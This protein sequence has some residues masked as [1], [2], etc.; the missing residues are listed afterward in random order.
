MYFSEIR[1]KKLCI[2]VM[3]CVRTLF[4][5]YVYA[6]VCCV[7]RTVVNWSVLLELI[8]LVRTRAVL[9]SRIVVDWYKCLLWASQLQR[10]FCHLKWIR[11]R[12][13][14]IGRKK[15]LQNSNN[16]VVHPVR[17]FLFVWI[18]LLLYYF[19]LDFVWR[20]YGQEK[21][22]EVAWLDG[23]STQINLESAR[24]L[25]TCMSDCQCIASFSPWH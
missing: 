15:T 13:V 11:Q 21:C 25:V 19:F 10:Y 4:S 16:T 20:K 3:G 12:F 18:R 23:K 5:L 6:T 1:Y 7:G 14:L 22:C 9:W 24:E 2:F 17:Y 8:F